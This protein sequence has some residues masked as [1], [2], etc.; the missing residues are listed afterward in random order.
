MRTGSQLR[1][2][3]SGSPVEQP[4]EWERGAAKDRGTWGQY[5]AV[6]S[7]SNSPLTHNP[8]ATLSQPFRIRCERYIFLKKCVH[9]SLLLIMFQ[10]VYVY[11]CICIMWLYKTYSCLYSFSSQSTIPNKVKTKAFYLQIHIFICCLVTWGLRIHW[12]LLCGGVRFP[13]NKCPGYGTKQSDGEA[14]VMLELWRMQST[15]S[16]PSLSRQLWP[17]VVA[18]DMTYGSNRTKQYAY[19]KLN[20]LK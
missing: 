20:C 18:P 6:C 15:P 9:S 14:T 3:P 1:A 2:G 17:R 5:V 13:P 16:L 7:V 11:G 12:L 19:A 4:A 8:F 10:H